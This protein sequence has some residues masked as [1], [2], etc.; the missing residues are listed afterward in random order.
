[1][2]VFQ[3]RRTHPGPLEAWLLTAPLALFSG[4]GQADEE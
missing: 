3:R 2:S 1:M 4:L